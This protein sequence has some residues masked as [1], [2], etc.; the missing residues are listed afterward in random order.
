MFFQPNM[1]SCNSSSLRQC[2]WTTQELA[3]NG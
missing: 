3:N 1:N 2:C